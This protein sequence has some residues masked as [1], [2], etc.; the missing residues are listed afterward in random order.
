MP[1]YRLD[2]PQFSVDGV[3]GRV[4]QPMPASSH[5]MAFIGPPGSGKTSL[6]TALLTQRSP[7]FYRKK[8]NHVHLFAPTTSRASMVDSPFANHPEEKLHDDLTHEDLRDVMDALEEATANEETSLVIIDDLASALKN[9][10]VR[11]LLERLAHNRRHLRT[12]VW[13]ISQTYMSLPLSMRKVLTHVVYFRARNSK[14]VDSMASEL[15][16][17]PRADFRRVYDSIFPPGASEAASH[18][19]ML[20]DTANGRVYKRFSEVQLYDATAPQTRRGD[21][22]AGVVAAADDVAARRPEEDA[23]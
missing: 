17:M 23:D 12:S 14:E 10:D 21:E 19:F 20:L 1:E 2:I 9:M 4:P 22:P 13:I 8:F 7:S 18:D 5:F 6:S 3:L 16:N 11:K 15:M